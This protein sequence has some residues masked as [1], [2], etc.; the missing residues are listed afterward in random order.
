MLGHT[1]H[2]IHKTHGHYGW[3]NSFPSVLTVKPGETVSLDRKSVV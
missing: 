3:D 2:T 1:D